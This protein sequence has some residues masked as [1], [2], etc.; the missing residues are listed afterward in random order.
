MVGRGAGDTL[1]ALKSNPAAIDTAI[2]IHTVEAL[3]QQRGWPAT[4]SPCICRGGRSLGQLHREK[5]QSL[6]SP[7]RSSFA[8][9]LVSNLPLKIFLARF[10][11]F[12]RRLKIALL[13]RLPEFKRMYKAKVRTSQEDF[14]GAGVKIKAYYSLNGIFNFADHFINGHSNYSRFICFIRIVLIF[15]IDWAMLVTQ[16]CLTIETSIAR[17]SRRQRVLVK[18]AEKVVGGTPVI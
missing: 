6:P 3:H 12:W 9:Q 1:A 18:S 11:S 8:T 5:L 2:T 16:I 10:H 7:N 14:G 4:R 17:R 15:S 13:D